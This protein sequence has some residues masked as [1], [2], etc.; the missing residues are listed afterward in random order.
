MNYKKGFTLIELLIVVAIVGLL[1]AVVIASL[2]SAREKGRIAA[3]L[4]LSKNLYSGFGADANGIWNLDEGSGTTAYNGG[5][6]TT[7]GVISGATWTTGPNKNSALSFTSGQR[8]NLGSVTTPINVT[9][10]AWI[11]TT[12]SSQQPV[13]SNRGNGLYFGVTGGK[14]FIY[15]NNSHAPGMT[16]VKS[17]NDNKW[18][19]VVW[20]SNGTTA[21]MY[22]DGQLDSSASQIRN[23]ND[24]GTAYIGYDAPNNEYFTGSV[25]EVAVYTQKLSQEEIQ[26]LYASGLTTI[27]A[28]R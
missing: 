23:N 26:H 9:V 12:S 19:H 7:S 4:T 10:A 13:F 20:T 22:V 15:Y 16:S 27:L 11:K 14:F 24:A 17:V 5:T 2:N 3:G 25:S 6:S 8:V 28:G 18:H 21:T 1:S